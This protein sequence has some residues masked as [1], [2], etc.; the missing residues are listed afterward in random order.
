MSEFRAAVITASNKGFSGERQD[1]SGLLV[2]KI[3]RE[4]GYS[5]AY[6]AILPDDRNMLAEAM[7]HLCDEEIADLILTTGG[8]GFSPRDFTPEATTDIAERMVPGIPEAMRAESMKI[9]NRAMLS[10]SVAALRRRTLIINLPGSPKAVQES[11]TCILPALEHGLE[12]LTGQAKECA[13]NKKESRD[14]K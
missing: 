8:T 12:I 1:A 3:L 5:I 4:A 2:Q 6:Y 14:Q 10:R 7:R 11:L 13:E 9:T